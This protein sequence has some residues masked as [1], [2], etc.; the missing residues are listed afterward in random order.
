MTPRPDNDAIVRDIEALAPDF[1]VESVEFEGEGDFCRAYTVNVD[2]IFR[3]AYNDEGSLSLKREAALL[4]K[5]APTVSTPIPNIKYFGR[6]RESGLAFVGYPKIH[7]EPLTY[8]RFMGLPPVRRIQV[9]N[10]LVLFLQQLH[11]FSLDDARALGV[12]E[13]DYPFC[14]T[15]EGI[16]QGS[17]VEL[18][19]RE[20]ALLTSHPRLA[21]YLGEATRQQVVA[22]CERLAHTL[23]ERPQAG[24]LPPALV[25]G[26]LSGEHILLDT[27]KM[28]IAGVI[29]FTDIVIT[30][31]AL[32][33]MYMSEAYGTD[34]MLSILQSYGVPDPKDTGSLVRR[35]H[36]WHTALRLLWA[37]DHDSRPLVERRAGELLR[38]SNNIN[39]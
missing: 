32:D 19:R 25:H 6:Q 2:W 20:L 9:A 35:L 34:I 26:D 39:G 8:D 13:C 30:T 3:F 14:R 4:P 12:P 37:L 5:L 23:T 17:A 1:Y 22:V 10:D 15:E 11:A 7:G 21:Q 28:A 38:E 18:Y 36:Q 27:G 33:F 16:T 29:D 24:D 31:P